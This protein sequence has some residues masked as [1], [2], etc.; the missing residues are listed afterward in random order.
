MEENEVLDLF[1][2]NE[3]YF[4][5]ISPGSKDPME[6][7]SKVWEDEE[8]YQQEER[9]LQTKLTRDPTG[10]LASKIASGKAQ[11]IEHKE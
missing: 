2:D 10:S 7:D 6:S 4:S 9:F 5:P 3:G 8:D 11:R 1:V